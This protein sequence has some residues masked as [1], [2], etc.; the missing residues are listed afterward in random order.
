MLIHRV[1]S[2]FLASFFYLFL[3]NTAQSKAFNNNV[4]SELT[5]T[6]TAKEVISGATSNDKILNLT[7][8][9]SAPT[10]DFTPS[11]VKVTNGKIGGAKRVNNTT[12]TAKFKAVKEGLTKIS[13]P[14]GKFSNAR[15]EKN[16]ASSE[17]TWTYDATPPKMTIEVKKVNRMVKSIKILVSPEKK[18]ATN[19]L[20]S[21]DEILRLH[22][23]TS[24]IISG[25]EISDIVVNGGVIS[26]LNG[27]EMNYSAI[28]IPSEP[29]KK[30]FELAAGSFADVA[31]NTN[32]FISFS[33]TYV[34]SIGSEYG[35]GLIAYLFTPHDSG[36]VEGEVHGLI[37]AKTDQSTLS[38]APWYN[39]SF[40]KT[41]ATGVEIGKGRRN[42]ELIVLKQGEIANEKIYA[43][44][45][46]SD[47]TIMEDNVLYD[48]WF[49]PSKDE[50]NKLFLNKEL[51]GNFE[52]DG[53]WSSTEEDR[54]G[55]WR[56]SFYNGYQNYGN[57]RSEG[58]EGAAS[59]YYGR[60]V[61]AVRTF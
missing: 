3:L 56:Q 50:L 30:D 10:K 4:V 46:C 5:M 1:T 29:G 41:G 25:F 59:G 36:Y 2:F 16:I 28:F 8:I 51:I 60:H 13:I 40:I 47:Y 61:R 57:K 9:S 14:A 18:T 42:T 22:F 20:P 39:G 31:G 43:A 55:A 53:Y 7:F 35:G 32:D 26:E 58:I 48:D 23:T 17:F 38:G 12:Y 21:D 52:G 37:A 49:L 45:L 24:E 34:P 33:S 19:T 27:G 44:K 11:D 54:E 15:G 6:I